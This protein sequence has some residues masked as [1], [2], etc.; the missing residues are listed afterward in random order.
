MSLFHKKET[1]AEEFLHIYTR[2][3]QLCT[4]SHG[5]MP[6][7]FR[8]GV[9]ESAAQQALIDWARENNPTIDYLDKVR[10]DVVSNH[11]S[12][13]QLKEAIKRAKAVLDDL[14]MRLAKLGAIQWAFRLVPSDYSEGLIPA[15]TKEI[16]LINT[17]G[18]S[19]FDYLK[20]RK[21][22]EVLSFWLFS[23]KSS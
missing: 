4:W 6:A 13:S 3:H 17:F 8:V 21:I 15:S 22:K 11:S 10:K 19:Y 20:I 14:D 5:R 18:W 12:K 7:A 23:A 16:K 2:V 9:Q 1:P